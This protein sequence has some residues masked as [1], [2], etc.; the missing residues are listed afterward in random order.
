MASL[1]KLG[2]GR[3][4]LSF[5]PSGRL[6]S[7]VWMLTDCL[8][9][10]K[11]QGKVCFAPGSYSRAWSR[12]HSEIYRVEESPGRRSLLPGTSCPSVVAFTLHRLKY[13]KKSLKLITEALCPYSCFEASRSISDCKSLSRLTFNLDVTSTFWQGVLQNHINLLST[14]CIPSCILGA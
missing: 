5:P 11:E 1:P 13:L 7:L 3:G 8:V 6:C 9:G 4:S 14:C 2:M 10:L 12:Q